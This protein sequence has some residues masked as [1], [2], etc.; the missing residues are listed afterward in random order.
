M[1]IATII[2]LISALAQLAPVITQEVEAILPTLEK[3]LNGGEATAEDVAAL[4]AVTGQVNA[5]IAAIEAK[6]EA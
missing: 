1:P 3:L 6:A 4:D 2:A 5:Q